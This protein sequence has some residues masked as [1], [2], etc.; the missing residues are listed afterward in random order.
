MSHIAMTDVPNA[1]EHVTVIMDVLVHSFRVAVEVVTDLDDVIVQEIIK[2]VAI[3]VAIVIH[4][5][6]PHQWH[7]MEIA[8][9]MVGFAMLDGSD[10]SF[11]PVHSLRQAGCLLQVTVAM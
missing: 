7:R 6:I 2:L 3:G 8:R 5:A 1:A 10:D 4:H 11:S 9:H